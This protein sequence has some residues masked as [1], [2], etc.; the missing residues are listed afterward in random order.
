MMKYEGYKCSLTSSIPERA[1][2]MLK[3]DVCHWKVEI[4]VFHFVLDASW[5]VSYLNLLQAKFQNSS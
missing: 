2:D 5:K 4:R 1:Y 3:R